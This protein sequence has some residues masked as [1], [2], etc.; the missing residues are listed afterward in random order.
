MSGNHMT[1]RQFVGREIRHARE[2]KQL[3]RAELAK[4]FPVSESLVASWETGRLIPKTEYIPHLTG[5]LGLP[6]VILRILDD[7]VSREVAP[8]WLDKWTRVECEATTLLWYES[9]VIPG[10]LQ[11]EEYAR[12]VLRLGKPSPLDLEGQVSTRLARQKALTRE[13]PPLY[14]AVLDEAV[15]RRPVGSPKTMRD[16]LIRLVELS[17]RDEVIIQVIPFEVGAHAGF[18]GPIVLASI[19]GAEVAYVDNA[20]RGEVVEKPEDVAAIRRLWQMLSAKALHEDASI[21]LITKAAHE[22]VT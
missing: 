20:L 8:E 19:N 16:Q 6:D 22:W 13:D 14:H 7:L 5:I 2:S 11:T 18:A 15:I 3:T 12:A 1:A 4:T 10:L 9:T 17:E 21:E